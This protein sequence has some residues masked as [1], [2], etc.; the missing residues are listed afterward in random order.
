LSPKEKDKGCH[1]NPISDDESK[2]LLTWVKI[3]TGSALL[4]A[5]C[6]TPG[7]EVDSQLSN[8]HEDWP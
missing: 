4:T 3:G 1:W 2:K 7:Q 5:E 8:G 6:S